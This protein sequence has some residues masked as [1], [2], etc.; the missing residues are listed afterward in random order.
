MSAGLPP[1]GQPGQH[2][3]RDADRASAL[4]VVD[5]AVVGCGA[6]GLMAA[7]FA[8]RELRRI[9]DDASPASE[10]RGSAGRAGRAGGI[11][12]VVA[13]DGAK[14]L[15]AKILVAGGGRCNVTHHRVDASDYA[16]STRNAIRRVLSAFDVER[17]IEFFRELGVELKREE[18]GKLFPTTDDAHTVLNALLRAA[19]DAGV[20]IVHPWRVADVAYQPRD[21]DDDNDAPFVVTRAAAPG[22]GAGDSAGAGA[23]DGAGIGAVEFIRAR[24]VVLA[25][26]GMALPRTGSDGAGYAIARRLGHSVTPRVVPALVPLTLA[27]G[28]FLRELSGLT[29]VTTLTLVGSTGKHLAQ[30]TGSTLLT[31]HGLSGPAAL[32]ISRYWIH[33]HHDDPGSR[34]LMSVVPGVSAAQLDEHLLASRRLSPLRAVDAIARE[35]GAESAPVPER[36]VRALCRAAGVDPVEPCD[37]LSRERRRALVD[38][39]CAFPLAIT[40]DRGFTYAEATAGGVPLSELHLGTMA[41]RVCPG[42]HLAGEVCDVDG[43]LGGFNFQWAWASGF[44]AGL[45]AAAALPSDAGASR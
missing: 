8:A 29:L 33:A 26:G 28:H 13:L 35:G 36:L 11:G 42:L 41:S 37:H 31:H 32:D 5:V 14:I 1:N 25:T 23:G 16:G 21:A 9:A 12:R 3:S 18:T 43:R 20:R 7:T 6:A 24:R 45:G 19:G 4:E 27:P 17:T 30:F 40:G 44:V 38:H 10:G 15:G 22:G 2:D 34:L 39:L